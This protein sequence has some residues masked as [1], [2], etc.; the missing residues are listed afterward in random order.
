MMMLAA[1]VSVDQVAAE[2]TVR[3]RVKSA[4]KNYYG[5]PPP[6]PPPKKSSKKSSKKNPPTEA[7]TEAP[8]ESP[9]VAPTESPT[10]APTD[11]PTVAPTVAPTDAP[12]VPATLSPVAEGTEGVIS[13]VAA[14]GPSPAFSADISTIAEFVEAL[15]D[16]MEILLDGDTATS[17]CIVESSAIQYAAT[18]TFC[19]DAFDPVPGSFCYEFQTTISAPSPGD[20]NCAINEAVEMATEELEDGGFENVIGPVAGIVDVFVPTDSP[21][22]LPTSDDEGPTEL[23]TSDDEGPTDAPSKGPTGAP[24]ESFYPTDAPIIP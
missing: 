19:T 24:T 3:R 7:P 14:P 18:D 4:E 1:L 6:P 2:A 11:S 5:P 8:T 13:G 21:T 16:A 20:P 9:T 17:S 10:V 15:D 22:E 23:P 12:T